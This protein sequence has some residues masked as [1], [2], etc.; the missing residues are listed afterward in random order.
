MEGDP[1]ARRRAD[2]LQAPKAYLPS[3]TAW[4]RQSRPPAS[5]A[6]GEILVGEMPGRQAGDAGQPREAHGGRGRG[7]GPD[8]TP[9]PGAGSRPV[10]AAT[11]ATHPSGLDS[12]AR[13]GGTAPA[14]DPDDGGSGRPSP[15]QGRTGARMGSGL[16]AE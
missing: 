7:E 2:G 10:S 1:L 3:Q 13:H 14:R 16:R 12:Q 15:A 9:T 11:G 8:A 6:P 4:Q 5:T